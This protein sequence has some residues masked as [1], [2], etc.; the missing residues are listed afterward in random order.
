MEGPEDGLR[1][2]NDVFDRSHVLGK[3]DLDRDKKWPRCATGKVIC[4]IHTLVHLCLRAV[5][6]RSSW[7]TGERPT[8]MSLS[9]IQ[10]E[11]TR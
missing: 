6:L 8:K 10:E 4:E 11:K 9:R 3:S 7:R 5:Y 2:S 1:G